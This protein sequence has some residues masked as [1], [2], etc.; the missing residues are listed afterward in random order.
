M[1]IEENIGKYFKAVDQWFEL[2]RN[3]AF[4]KTFIIPVC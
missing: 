2:M 4:R 3:I 1:T